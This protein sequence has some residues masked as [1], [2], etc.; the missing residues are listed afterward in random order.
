MNNEDLLYDLYYVK[1]NFDGANILYN[2]AR[3]INKDITFDDVKDWLNR[4]ATHQQTSN[5]SKRLNFLPIYSESPFGFQIDLTFFPRYTKQNDGYYVLFTAINI[6]TRYAYAYYSKSKD[7]KTILEI[8]KQFHI[9]CLMIDTITTDE[10]TEFKNAF[11]LKYCED[12]NIKIFFCK[13]DSHKLGIINRF[14]RTLK[15]KLLKYFTS[16]DT[17]R[18][19][20]EIDKIIYNYNHTVNTGIDIE[21]ANANTF[22]QS[23]IISERQALTEKMKDKEPEYLIG[24]KCRILNTKELFDDKMTAQYSNKIYTITKVNKNSIMLDN[25]INIKKSNVLKITEDTE[26]ITPEVH[27]KAVKEFNIS[28]NK[29]VRSK[30]DVNNIIHTVREKR[31]PTRYL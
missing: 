9:D 3:K 1:L 14:H 16:Q 10:G 5:T 17:V 18:W 4:Q 29:T 20:G 31:T 13:G 27:Q 23:D 24:G 21:P 25:N 12:N 7:S 8:M 28:K 6:N 26:E 30:V 2:K 22:I 15:D 11:F 19:V